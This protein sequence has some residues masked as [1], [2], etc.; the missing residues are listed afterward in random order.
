MGLLLRGRSTLPFDKV[1]VDLAFTGA[2]RGW[3]YRGL[4]P[5]VNTDLSKGMDGARVLTHAEGTRHVWVLY[6][7][8]QSGQLTIVARQHDWDPG[9]EEDLDYA[10]SVIDGDVPRDGWTALADAFLTRLDR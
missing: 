2:W 3:E 4:F 10:L 5:Q 8:R 1:R 9:D 6:W 7:T